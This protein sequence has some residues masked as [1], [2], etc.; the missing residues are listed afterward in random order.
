MAALSQTEL[1]GRERWKGCSESNREGAGSEPAAS[2]SSATPLRSGAGG[3]SRT[4]N[5]RLTKPLLCQLSHASAVSVPSASGVRGP[6]QSPLALGHVPVPLPTRAGKVAA[7]REVT[8]RVVQPPL[9]CR[10]LTVPVIG[11]AALDGV[12]SSR[13]PSHSSR[14]CTAGDTRQKWSG[15]PDSN[16]CELLASSLEGWRS[17]I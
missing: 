1:Q 2:T 15:L 12:R 10:G 7:L 14:A 8:P 5:L 17:T 13:A 11:D 16:R 6:P 9:R 4:R 3:G